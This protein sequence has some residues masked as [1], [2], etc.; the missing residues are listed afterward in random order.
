MAEA[1]QT[2]GRNYV[3]A[4]LDQDDPPRYR[5]A[6]TARTLADNLVDRWKW[7]DTS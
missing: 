1:R 6:N 7:T 4:V 5:E 3:E 2:K